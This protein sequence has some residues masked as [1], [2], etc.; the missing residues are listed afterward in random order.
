M[1][2]KIMFFRKATPA[3]GVNKLKLRIIITIQTR[4]TYLHVA[5]L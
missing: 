4:I 1:F 2:S 5:E 3:V